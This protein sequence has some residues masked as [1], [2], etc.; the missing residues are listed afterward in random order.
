MNTEPAAP[1]SLR[2]IITQ[3]WQLFE[4]RTRRKI[5][6]SAI[7]SAIL[8]AMDAIGVGLVPRLI[9]EFVTPSNH[10]GFLGNTSTTA[11]ALVIV[12]FL[13]GKSV[14]SGLVMIWQSSF[15]ANDEG[16]RSVKMFR[17]ILAMPYLETSE[18]GTAGLIRDLH[19]AM[20]QLYRAS[21]GGLAVLISDGLGLLG[22]IVVIFLSS[23]IMGLVLA[24]VLV[25]AAQLYSRLIRTPT[26]KLADRLQ[27][28]NRDF[29]NAIGESFGGLKTLKAFGVE[30][31]IT[32]R[33]ASVRKR[34]SA[35]ARDVLVYSQVARYYLEIVLVVG[36]GLCLGV[37]AIVKGQG[38]ILAS[39]GLLSGVAARAMPALA[40]ALTAVT[41]IKVSGTAVDELAPDLAA[42]DELSDEPAGPAVPGEGP[43]VPAAGGRRAGR[44]LSVAGVRFRYPAR[45]ADALRGIS[46]DLAPGE[47]VAIQGESGAGKTTLVDVV[48]GLITPQEGAVNRPGTV[49][50]VAQETF[51]WNDTVTF[52]V[53][54]GRPTPSDNFESEVWA[55]LEAAR[56]GDWARRLP[57]RLETLLGER[58]SHMSGGERQRLGVARALF[59]H[60][61]VLLLDEP[62]SAL[63]TAT[64]RSLMATLVAIK[65]QV[66]VMVVTHDPV[67]VEYADR[68]IHLPTAGGV[69]AP[70]APSA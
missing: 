51:V 50:Y 41:L 9:R 59:G 37:Q 68:T 28:D 45:E 65:E 8:A 46:L 26:G 20:P 27:I 24:M 2:H 42:V 47:L 57:G 55:S 34:Y 10:S 21:G 6:I 60:P 54:L 58:G 23:P 44:L 7:L 36:L 30:D 69:A 66:G 4:P 63:D 15:L 61:G 53:V 12:A 11:V 39:F 22:L 70:S 40:R 48:I 38:A 13:I 25:L 29:L 62:T 49:G 16:E 14:G 19:V 18:R 31:V 67:V 5:V 64:S 1:R 3:T 56:L 43:T 52:N 35:T 33:F 17:R 32:S